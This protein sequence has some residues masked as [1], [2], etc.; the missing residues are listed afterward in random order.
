MTLPG[1]AGNI[2]GGAVETFGGIDIALCHAG[3]VV[4][5]GL[6]VAGVASHEPGCEVVQ[7]DC[8]L[9]WGSRK[10]LTQA[11]ESLV[12]MYPHP[13]PANGSNVDDRAL[14]RLN[15]LDP[16]NLH[17]GTALQAFM[18]EPLGQDTLTDTIS[19]SFSRRRP[20]ERSP[21]KKIALEYLNAPAGPR[22]RRAP[23]LGGQRSRS[24]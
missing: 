3:I 9:G 8:L 19:T 11:D 6:H 15:D 22:R 17:F 2:V 18:L 10:R 7:K 4:P 24:E 14:P 5:D 20:P 21:V 12:G 16:G 13:K 23:D 1:A